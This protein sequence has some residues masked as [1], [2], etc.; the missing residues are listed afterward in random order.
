VSAHGDE[1]VAAPA[2]APT[3]R[4]AD[5]ANLD[6]VVQRLLLLLRPAELQRLVSLGSP[7]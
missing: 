1:L 7:R 6:L 4:I 2:S 5:L 3:Q